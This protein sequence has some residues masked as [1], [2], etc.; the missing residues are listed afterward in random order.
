VITGTDS[1]GAPI[2]LLNEDVLNGTIFMILV[3]CTIASFAAQRGAQ[4]IALEESADNGMPTLWNA[5]GFFNRKQRG[6][7]R[8]SGAV[9]RLHQAEGEKIAV[10][11]AERN[12]HRRLR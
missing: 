2:R 3:T 10:V 11:C 7:S 12:Q 5:N 8:R 4:N 9:E 6:N 1:N